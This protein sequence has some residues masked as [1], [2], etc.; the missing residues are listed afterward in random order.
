MTAPEYLRLE[1]AL[2]R[3]AQSGWR[4]SRD[5]QG[6]MFHVRSAL[7]KTLDPDQA[8]ALSGLIMEAMDQWQ[9]RRQVH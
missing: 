2:S 7:A 1:S 3:L 6:P 4:W 9:E 8:A 5:D